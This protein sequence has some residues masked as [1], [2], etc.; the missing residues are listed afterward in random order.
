MERH[1]KYLILALSSIIC[2]KTITILYIKN[3]Y[4][5]LEYPNYKKYVFILHAFLSFIISLSCSLK[6]CAK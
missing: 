5:D 3:M 6:T 2:Q 4:K 1:L